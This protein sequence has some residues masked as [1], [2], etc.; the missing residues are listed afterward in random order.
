[1]TFLRFL[2]CAIAFSL[3]L[4]PGWCCALPI[5]KVEAAASTP[6][7]APA[8]KSCCHQ[9]PKPVPQPASTPEKTPCQQPGQKCCCEFNSTTPPAPE[10]VTHDVAPSLSVPLDVSVA[11]TLQRDAIETSGF[12]YSTPSLQILQCVW[13]C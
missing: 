2:A 12:V 1:M 5:R 8:S 10:K 6:I 4:P 7:P 13:R 3:A 11:L 9:E